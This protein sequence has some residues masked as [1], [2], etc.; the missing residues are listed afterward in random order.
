MAWGRDDMAARA[1]LE[2]TDGCYVNLG[3]GIPTLISDHIPSHLRVILHSE[4]GMLA[5]GPTAAEH[6]RDEDI[7]NA[8]GVA[9]RELAASSYFDSSASFAMIRGGHLSLSFLGGMQVAQNGDLANWMAPGATLRGMGGAMD[10]VSGVGRVVVLMQHTDRAG[11]SKLV[12][13]CS[14]PLTGAGV[15]DLVITDL[16][17][18]EIRPQMGGIVVRE[19]APGVSFEEACSRTAANLLLPTAAA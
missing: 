2:L 5:V 7:I 15:V 9:V 8:G 4:N 10:L 18:F 1:A 13:R 19:L 3:V 11:S 6:E 14:L 17:A 12:Q 16:G